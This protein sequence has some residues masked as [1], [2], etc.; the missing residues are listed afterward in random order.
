MELQVDVLGKWV[1]SCH[2]DI[3]IRRMLHV[4]KL[5]LFKFSIRA[6]SPQ[7]LCLL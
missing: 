3:A 1:E 7:L 2:Q 4:E 6:T 5:I